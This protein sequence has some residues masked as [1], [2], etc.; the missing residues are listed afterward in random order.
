MMTNTYKPI[1]GGLERS[2]ET[3]SRELRR[4]GH[5]VLIVAPE[6]DAA[7]EDEPGVLRVPAIRNLT[8]SDYSLPLPLPAAARAALKRY[9]PDVIHA[10]HPFF[11]GGTGLVLA[12]ELLAPLVFTYHTMYESYTHELPADSAAVKEFVVQYAVRYANLCDAVL[13]P[14]ASVAAVLRERGVETGIT[15]VPTGIDPE[16]FGQGDGAAFRRKHGIPPESF[17]VGYCGRVTREKNI[18][19]LAEGVI[20]LLE[21]DGGKRR[22][23]GRAAAGEKAAGARAAGSGPSSPGQTRPGNRRSGR[24]CSGAECRFLI[25]GDGPLLEPLRRLFRERGLEARLHAPGFLQGQELADGYHAMDA[26]AFASRSETQGLVVGEAMAAGLPVVALDG[27][28][29][30]DI[31][32]DGRSG[33]LVRRDSPSEL[34][35]ALRWLL[36]LEPARRAALAAEALATARRFSVEACV[37]RALEVYG[38]VRR[39]GR[40]ER[41][42]EEEGY[43]SEARRNLAMEWKLIRSVAGSAAG[44]VGR[45]ASGRSDF[46]EEA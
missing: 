26:F 11:L 7:P 29:V 36:A 20:E 27:P 42:S 24:A 35:A 18:E 34:A 13:A 15:V 6:F 28:G 39:R 19:L 38:A 9:R 45:V 30:R 23:R 1:V 4:R 44:A 5:E 25:L 10:H 21:G 8:E 32:E 12:A 31:L 41:G 2:V 17:L 33:R 43:W 16:R 14:S 40:K 22:R 37:E 46:L 3:F